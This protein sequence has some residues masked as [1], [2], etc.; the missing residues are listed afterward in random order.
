MWLAKRTSRS[1]PLDAGEVLR[2]LRRRLPDMLARAE[3][4]TS[5]A[6]LGL[7]SIDFVELLCAVEDEFGVQLSEEELSAA[8]AG[9]TAERIAAKC[10][11]DKEQS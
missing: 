5:F 9:D 2:R 8:C 6:D 10:A 4:E 1:R 11:A 3:V 7:D